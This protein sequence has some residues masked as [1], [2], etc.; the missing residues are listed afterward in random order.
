MGVTR[1]D[2]V[3]Y[4]MIGLLEA[5]D[6]FDPH[7]GIGFT[8]FAD[9]RIRGA[10]LD[11]LRS[12]DPFSRRKRRLA[13]TLRAAQ[14]TVA[15]T[16]G[17]EARPEEVADAMG[18]DL[19]EYWRA[20]DEVQPVRN[21]SLHQPQGGDDEGR[22]VPLVEKIMDAS[23]RGQDARVLA[24]QV[25]HHLRDAIGELPAKERD[26]VLMYYG[27]DMSCAEIAKVYGVTVSRVSQIL[28]AART[29]LRKKLNPVVD[30]A[31]LLTV[32]GVPAPTPGMVPRRSGGGA[33]GINITP[34]AASR[35]DG[36][37]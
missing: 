15:Q 30:H 17:R 11:A 18:V 10:M 24:R 6:R 16:E 32:E 25:R 19:E 7:R 3:S 14:Q 9:Y 8:A 1:E 4:G 31:D 34:G 29:R 27:R 22:G 2:L 12:H 5:F 20:V 13:R 26:C 21:V 37:Q 23:E 35:P 36:D 28:R 33:T